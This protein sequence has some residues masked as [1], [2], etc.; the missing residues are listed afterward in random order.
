M[1]DCMDRYK[2][3][4]ESKHNKKDEYKKTTEY[5]YD[6]VDSLKDDNAL[7]TLMTLMKVAKSQTKKALDLEKT[8]KE[9]AELVIMSEKSNYESIHDYSEYHKKADKFLKDFK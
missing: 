6:R 3:E 8:A 2:E 7:V 9:F 1:K 4:M 5:L